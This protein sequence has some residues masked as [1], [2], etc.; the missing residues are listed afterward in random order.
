M[1]AAVIGFL[2]N[3]AVAV[4]RIKVGHEIGSAALVADGYHARVD[5][6]TSL[7]VL[8]GA[9]GVWAGYPLADPL[10]GLLITAV[11]VRIVWQSSAT[12][13]TRLLDGVDPQVVEEIRHAAQHTPGVR[14]VTEVRARWLGHRLH[15]ELNLAVQADLSVQDGHAIATAVRHNL[16]HHLR[17][18]A[19]ATIHVD[20]MQASGE[21][22]HR[23]AAHVHDDLPPHAHL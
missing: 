3:E 10:V 7:A 21:A 15:A 2:G 9:V 13:F 23:I 17:Y 11:I 14:E 18:L 8:G 4:L 19:Q 5:G 6:L 1:S 20:P 16:L 22:H 12:V